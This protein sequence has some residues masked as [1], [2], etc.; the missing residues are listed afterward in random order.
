MSGER[1]DIEALPVEL[2]PVWHTFPIESYAAILKTGRAA[3]TSKRYDT[4]ED[5]ARDAHAVAKAIDYYRTWHPELAPTTFG[6]RVWS[7]AEDG[8]FR[9]AIMPEPVCGHRPRLN[10]DSRSRRGAPR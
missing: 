10:R 3:A 1:D 2:V 8:R 6:V 5:A 7:S 9:W 4:R